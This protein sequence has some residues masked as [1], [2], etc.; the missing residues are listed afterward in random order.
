ME[1]INLA[2]IDKKYIWMA[3]C[4]TSAMLLLIITFGII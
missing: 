4:V 2:K 3:I 1:S